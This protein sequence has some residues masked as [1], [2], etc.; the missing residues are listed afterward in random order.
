MKPTPGKSYAE[1]LKTDSQLHWANLL[2]G[3]TLHPS[4]HDIGL[5]HSPTP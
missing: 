4:G 3:G 2:D 5:A 1:V